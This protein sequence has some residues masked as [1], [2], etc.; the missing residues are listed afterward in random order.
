MLVFKVC[1]IDVCLCRPIACAFERRLPVWGDVTVSLFGCV[2]VWNRMLW[3]CMFTSPDIYI[4]IYTHS[5]SFVIMLSWNKCGLIMQQLC[6]KSYDFNEIFPLNLTLSIQFFC[7]FPTCI[8]SYVLCSENY[9]SCHPGTLSSVW[10]THNRS[11]R[12]WRACKSF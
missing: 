3:S 4:H 6:N 8:F 2:I 7:F 5:W 1:R 10:G 11:P 12:E 9:Q